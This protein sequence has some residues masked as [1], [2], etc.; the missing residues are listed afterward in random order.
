VRLS[1]VLAVALAGCAADLGSQVVE[2]PSE[3][4]QLTALFAPTPDPPR[5]GATELSITLSRTDLSPVSGATFDVV[6]WMPAH[7]HGSPRTPSTSEATPGGYLTSDLFYQMAGSWE[8]RITVLD[9][10]GAS[11]GFVVPQEVR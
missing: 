8:L 1:A 5:V 9:A 2:L 4:G 6:P 7:G 3:D 10:T 11:H